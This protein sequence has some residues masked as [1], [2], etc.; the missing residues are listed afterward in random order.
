[1]EALCWA[2]NKNQN[3]AVSKVEKQE[4]CLD[5]F[6]H[7]DHQKHFYGATLKKKRILET[8]WFFTSRLFFFFYSQQEISKC[9]YGCTGSKVNISTLTCKFFLVS[10]IV[11]MLISWCWYY[12][13]VQNINVRG[14]WVKDIWKFRHLGVTFL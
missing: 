8:C 9:F 7:L 4:K 2:G 1:M 6:L 3:P 5:P 13:Y 14:S 12:I 10:D 11:P